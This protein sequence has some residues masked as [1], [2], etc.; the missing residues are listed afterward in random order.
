[1][2][3]IASTNVT[4]TLAPQDR[5]MLGFAHKI[6]FPTIAF[7]NGSLTY[8][9]NGVP[10]PA[11]GQFG[12]NKVIKRMRLDGIAGYKFV[13]DAAHHTIRIFQSPAVASLTCVAAT[14]GTP[15]GTNAAENAHTHSV[16]SGTDAGGGTT[17]AGSSH[18]HAFTGTQL[19]T[20]T[21]DITGEGAAGA[22]VEIGTGDVC[23]TATLYAEVVGN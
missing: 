19:A 1:M 5:D 10:L 16:P 14:A 7:G 4:V 18:N 8:P 23:P 15:A 21:H 13:Y 20:H 22:M 11:I 17:G 2:G 9:A 6:S 3:A 12:M